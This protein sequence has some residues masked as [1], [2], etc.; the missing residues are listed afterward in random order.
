MAR[1]SYYP[2]GYR[3]YSPSA[4]GAQLGPDLQVVSLMDR[5]MNQPATHNSWA[6]KKEVVETA[7]RLFGNDVWEWFEAQQN[8]PMLCEDGYGFLEDCLEYFQTGKRGFSIYSRTSCFRTDRNVRPGDADAMLIS[9][10]RLN[11]L[12]RFRN[13]PIKTNLHPLQ[14]WLIKKDG[15]IDLLCSIYTLFGP[16]GPTPKP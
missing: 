6:F 14:A 2:N 13:Q 3:A 8:N 11:P 9:R 10:K 4:L 1:F 16:V 7:I 15:W 5:F 12:S